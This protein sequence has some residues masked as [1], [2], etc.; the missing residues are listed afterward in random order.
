LVNL[1]SILILDP[2]QCHFVIL[3]MEC[4]TQLVI[5][6]HTTSKLTAINSHPIFPANFWFVSIEQQE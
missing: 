2:K 6:S 4:F 5:L 1:S 3:M